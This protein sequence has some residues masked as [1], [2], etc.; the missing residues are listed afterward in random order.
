MNE[1][2][3]PSLFLDSNKLIEN[4]LRLLILQ[5]KNEVKSIYNQQ[6]KVRCSTLESCMNFSWSTSTNFILSNSFFFLLSLK[7]FHYYFFLL[8][9]DSTWKNRIDPLV[10]LLAYVLISFVCILCS[11]RMKWMILYKRMYIKCKHAHFICRWDVIR[12]QK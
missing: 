1:I 5:R 12:R 10:H 2:Y 8:N 3:S 4:N 11:N 6:E 7:L 9:I